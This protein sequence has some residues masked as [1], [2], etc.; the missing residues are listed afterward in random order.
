MTIGRSEI[1][2]KNKNS[3][4]MFFPQLCSGPYKDSFVDCPEQVMSGDY[5]GNNYTDE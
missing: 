1:G 4:L 3:G 2:H 5:I